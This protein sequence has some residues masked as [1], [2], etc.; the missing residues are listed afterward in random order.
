MNGRMASSC[1]MPISTSVSPSRRPFCEPSASAWSSCCGVMRSAPMS[2]WPSVAR[3]S[4]RSGR[5]ASLRGAP[6]RLARGRQ[7]VARSPP[8]NSL[9][10]APHRAARVTKHF[11][12]RADACRLQHF[13]TQR[14][15]IRQLQR[16]AHPLTFL[17]KIQQQLQARAIDQCDRLA[18]RARSAAARATSR[19]SSMVDSSA[20]W[21]PEIRSPPLITS[22]APWRLCAN[23]GD[24]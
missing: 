3:P 8:T 18:N 20:T 19:A 5:G 4:A 9:H 10:K 16:A 15:G 12:P 6:G 21:S 7:R 1:T 11:E 2:C 24:R 23:I 17:L 14:A 22:T 13:A